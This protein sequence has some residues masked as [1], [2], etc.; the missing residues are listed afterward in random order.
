[1]DPFGDLGHRP[2]VS[3]RATRV[4]C[5]VGAAATSVFLAG[6]LF[7][8]DP[9]VASNP[10]PKC[11]LKALTGLDCPGCGGLRATHSM[12]HGDIVGAVSHNVL[13][14]VMVPLMAYLLLRWV[15]GLWG[16]QLPTLKLPRWT[17]WAIPIFVLAFTVLRNIP[18]QPF[19]WFN[20]FSAS[21]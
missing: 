4:A 10:Y 8:V 9:N 7:A 19:Y 13:A 2:G 1:M 6:Y 15:L 11:P 12:L 16:Y 18:N 21:A 20:S 3:T 5:T 17:A 14:V